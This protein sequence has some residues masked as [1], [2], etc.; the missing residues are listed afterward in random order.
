M[1]CSIACL[2]I[3]LLV[4]LGCGEAQKAQVQTNPVI[5][6]NR[7]PETISEKSKTPVESKSTSQATDEESEDASQ[8]A[9]DVSQP[10]SEM[11]IDPNGPLA[12]VETPM[13]D[14]GA[15][16]PGERL[17]HEFVVHNRGKEPL[18]LKLGFTTC[19]CTMADIPNQTIEPG[20]FGV[21][22]LEANTE[23]K[24]G[25]FEQGAEI[26]T[27]QR[28][29]L[30]V[31]TVRMRGYVNSKILC[32]V[33]S[34]E[35]GQIHP[36]RSA[37]RQ[38]EVISQRW[39]DFKIK[40]F[41]STSGRI[42]CLSE[43]L[44]EETLK[45]HPRKPRSGY[46]ITVT[47][48][49]PGENGTEFTDTLTLKTEGPNGETADIA[50]PIRANVRGKIA[51]SANIIRNQDDLSPILKLGVVPGGEEKIWNINVKVVDQ[52]KQLSV[53]SVKVKPDFLTVQLLTSSEEA[54]AAGRYQLQIKLPANAPDC[55]YV[56][57]NKGLIH[58]EYD[59]PRIKEANFP[60]E[61]TV[62]GEIDES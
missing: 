50:L 26:H 54:K 28:G 12:E 23:G 40:E 16:E 27:N 59:H 20:G 17:G 51:Y 11:A 31:F 62:T 42:S 3:V 45:K 19:R 34:L 58:I 30:T 22:R 9:I 41:H 49:P 47:V 21:V 57:L 2:P 39:G 32:D 36:G 1:R 48:S 6:E 25:E 46:E 18:V 7:A 37:E 4:L 56:G 24:F 52:E 15:I 14:F 5:G 61:L 8:S 13:Y 55:Q 38:V 60:L 43:M 44:D 33:Q 35:F 10:E 29:T 53:K